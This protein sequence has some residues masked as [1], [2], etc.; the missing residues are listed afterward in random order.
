V[1]GIDFKTVAVL[2]GIGFLALLPTFFKKRLAEKF[3]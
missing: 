1:G 3:E 2:F